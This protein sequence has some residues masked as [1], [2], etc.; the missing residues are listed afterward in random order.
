MM[1]LVPVDGLGRQL[2]CRWKASYGELH[3]IK[4]SQ[5]LCSLEFHCF[6]FMLDQV[7]VA[8][9]WL[10]LPSFLKLSDTFDSELLSFD[11]RACAIGRLST[12]GSLLSD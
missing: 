9:D 2:I 3:I 5:F 7:K 4:S 6:D 1:N 10:T 11:C 8:S 12:L